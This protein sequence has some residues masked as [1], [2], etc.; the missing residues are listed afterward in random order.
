MQEKGSKDLRPGTTLVSLDQGPRICKPGAGAVYPPAF[1]L[2]RI[3]GSIH[4]ARWCMS[5]VCVVCR[6]M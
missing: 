3:M 6:R 1:L 2:A 5:S 4:F